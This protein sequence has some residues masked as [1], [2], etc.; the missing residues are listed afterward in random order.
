MDIRV[1]GGSIQEDYMQVALNSPPPVP[2]EYSFDYQEQRPL[3]FGGPFKSPYIFELLHFHWG[4]LKESGTEH[5]LNS[6]SYHMEM[7]VTHRHPNYPD[8]TEAAK[9]KNGIVV[10]AFLFEVRS[11]RE[12]QSWSENNVELVSFPL[13]FEQGD[14]LAPI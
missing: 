3:L 9:Y 2:V 1:S 4:P 12:G 7:H 5:F 11:G 8:M 6:K 13:G 14:G 10:L